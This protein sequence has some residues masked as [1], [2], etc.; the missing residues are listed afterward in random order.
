MLAVVK[1]RQKGTTMVSKLPSGVFR[2]MLE[3]EFPN[4]FSYRYSEPYVP[5][6]EAQ[7][8]KFP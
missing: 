4:E 8:R 5:I 2:H 3:Y 1:L 6:S 7:D